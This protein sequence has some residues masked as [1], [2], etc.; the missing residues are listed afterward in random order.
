MI[1]S[2][3]N[4]SNSCLHLT[5]CVGDNLIASRKKVLSLLLIFLLI[6]L[7]PNNICFTFTLDQPFS[8]LP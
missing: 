6:F 1:G 7:R 5:I 4:F 2:A 8:V 3:A